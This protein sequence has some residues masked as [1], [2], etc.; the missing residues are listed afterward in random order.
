MS[1]DDFLD[2]IQR[3]VDHWN[4]WREAH[5]Q[6]KPDL[7]RCYLFQA[8]LR[9]ANLQGV[10]FNRTCL[11]GADLTH[12]NLTGADLS[13]VYAS[14][15]CFKAANLERANL[16]GA[17]LN[18]SNLATARLI[19]VQADG[20]DFSAAC[21]S[22]I[23]LENWSISPATKFERIDCTHVYLRP[24]EQG[25]YPKNSDFKPGE[26]ATLI[27]EQPD[28]SAWAIGQFSDEV[29]TEEAPTAKPEHDADVASDKSAIAP[30][31]GDSTP[32]AAHEAEPE[33]ASQAERSPE[34]NLEQ[35]A[36]PSIPDP[37]LDQAAEEELKQA[38]SQAA[39]PT[40]PLQ[41]ASSSPEPVLAKSSTPLSGRSPTDRLQRQ[42]LLSPT[43]FP[44]RQWGSGTQIAAIVLGIGAIASI[45]IVSWQFMTRSFQPDS[46]IDLSDLPCTESPLRDVSTQTPTHV[47][48]NGTQFYGDFEDGAPADGRGTMIFANGDRYDGEFQHGERHGCGT[49]TFANGRQYVGQFKD[50]Q[51]NGLGIW[52]LETGDRYIGEFKANKCD[53]KGTFQF[54]DG[55]TQTGTWRDGLLI[56]GNLSCS[57]GT[58]RSPDSP[59]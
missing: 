24:H 36:Q 10:I 12:A 17:N 54:T 11:I 37:W 2:L 25:R 35:E 26:F 41:P 32:I 5:P 27:R 46:A 20:A 18:E 53:G 50:D 3:G 59:I 1:D 47:Y 9:G 40:I 14:G 34:P 48:E 45:A 51:F 31:P 38:D 56:D 15:A 13:G 49:L 29:E 57:E 4:Q 30:H 23:Y 8:D 21:L 19:N 43:P 42:R 44:K 6:A 16:T 58:V 39:T 28:V 52:T 7:S 22:G 55:S 33:S